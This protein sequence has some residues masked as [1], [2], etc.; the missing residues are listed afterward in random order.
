MECDTVTTWVDTSPAAGVRSERPGCCRA[1]R[2]AISWKATR[3]VRFCFRRGPPK[4]NA[5]ARP[6]LCAGTP[7]WHAGCCGR[8]GS[9]GGERLHHLGGSLRR[10]LFEQFTKETGI[11]V[12]WIRQSSSVILA[13]VIAEKDNPQAT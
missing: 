7:A 8:A 12:R 5:L 10:P 13:R 3:H 9:T 6:D 4:R 1:H 2:V 11:Q